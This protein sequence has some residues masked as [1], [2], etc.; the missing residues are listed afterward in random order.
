MSL[1]SYQDDIHFVLCGGKNTNFE[2]ILNFESFASE[3][4]EKI[5]DFLF[6]VNNVKCLEDNQLVVNLQTRTNKNL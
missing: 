5:T 3:F 4:L 2:E 6:T 1:F